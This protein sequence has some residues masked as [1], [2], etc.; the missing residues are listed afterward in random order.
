MTRRTVTRTRGPAGAIEIW[1]PDWITL[2]WKVPPAG[3]TGVPIFTEAV[4][5]IECTVTQ[6]IEL[7]SHDL[8]I[9]EVVDAGFHDEREGTPVARMSDTRMKYGG[10]LRGGHGEK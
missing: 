9:G 4:A 5:Y 1:P 10:V 2:H 8:F 3:V 6:T 7:G